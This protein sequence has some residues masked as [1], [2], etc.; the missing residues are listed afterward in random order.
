M[1]KPILPK[2]LITLIAASC[3]F[4]SFAVGFAQEAKNGSTVEEDLTEL[5]SQAR[6]YREAG[7][8]KQRIGNLTEALGLYQKA[9]A[10]DPSYAVAYN[11]LG[12]VYEA[13]GSGD[14][15]LDN[16]LKALKID[17][18]YASVYTNLAL[19]YENQR[20]L[21]KAAFY[22]DK[23][24]GVGSL[25]DPW[26]Q[27]AVNRLK[28]VRMALSKQP[29][30]DQR[31]DEVL[32]LLKDVVEDKST[33]DKDSKTLSQD[34]FKKAKDSFKQNDLATAVKEALDAQYLDQ[35]NPEIEAFIEKTT[36]KALSK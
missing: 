1:N 18:A 5:Q 3:V 6:I 13:M 15:A 22:W 4:F 33:V 10:I 34:H 32:G 27:K 28:D 21:D 14:R 25:D 36:L 35:D 23:R 7:L 20:D 29:I 30:S 8:E 12:V 9:I 26:T 31:E 11:D 17:P 19:Y 16:Y 24:V 2:F